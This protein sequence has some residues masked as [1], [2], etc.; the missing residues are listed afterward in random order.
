[1]FCLV[2]A[3]LL[4]LLVP[5]IAALAVPNSNYRLHETRRHAHALQKRQTPLDPDAII[6]IKIALTQTNLDDAHD[7]LMSVAHPTSP[8]YGQH[9]SVD[10]INELFAPSDET[11]DAVRT[12]FTSAADLDEHSVLVSKNGWLV[13]NIPVRTAERVF[14]TRYYEHNDRN[15]R[16]RIG[17]DAYSI[18]SHLQ[19]HIDY[20]TPGVKSSPPLRKRTAGHWPSPWQGPGSQ[21]VHW[22]P[23]HHGPW[24]M[25]PGAQHLPL[26][27]QDC[28]RN[29]TPTCIRALYGIPMAQL[30]DSVNALGLYEQGDTYA[31]EDLNSFFTMYAPNV[32]NNTAPIP[33][34]ID[35]ATAPVPVDDPNNT[36]ESDIDMD[37]AFSLI[38]PQ[39]V[40]LYQVD[41]APQSNLS[42]YGLLPGFMNTF[43][44]ALDGSYCNY[45]YD[46]LTGNTPNFDPTYPDPLPGGLQGRPSVRCLH[47]N[48]SD[49]HILWRSW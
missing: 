5:E 32:P 43:L 33:Q 11:I 35:G 31:Q 49:Q 10:D 30:N 15:G 25:P 48:S 8:S 44:D 46:G 17:C 34:F 16:S 3:A 20:I 29:I 18:P 42:L 37:I 40:V 9:L 13:A 27:L 41:D 14:A 38:Y 47:A 26:D 7:Y 45:S 39:N 21:P 28:G 36:G 19:P 23:H 24:H 4:L 6:P 12:W 22:D 1:M 2:P